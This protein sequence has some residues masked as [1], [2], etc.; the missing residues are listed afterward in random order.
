[1]EDS[2]PEIKWHWT[3]EKKT[4]NYRPIK[5]DLNGLE[6]RLIMSNKRELCEAARS[7]VLVFAQLITIG[8]KW[9]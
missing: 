9:N 6:N 3:R 7:H 5:F 4:G 8:S 1:M 2:V